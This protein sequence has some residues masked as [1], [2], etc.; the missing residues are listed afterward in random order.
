MHIVGECST[1]N[2]TLLN[3]HSPQAQREGLLHPS[4]HHTPIYASLGGDIPEEVQSP[5]EEPA[6]AESLPSQCPLWT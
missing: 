3:S 5:I 4:H 2:L 1:K 6:E